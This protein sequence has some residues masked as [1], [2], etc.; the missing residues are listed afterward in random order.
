MRD[1]VVQWLNLYRSS[2]FLY[3]ELDTPYNSIL[4]KSH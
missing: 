3:Q 2:E 1:M 4:H